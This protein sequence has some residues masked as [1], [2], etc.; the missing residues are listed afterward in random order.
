MLAPRR[1]QAVLEARAST[2]PTPDTEEALHLIHQVQGFPVVTSA[3]TGSDLGDD[4]RHRNVTGAGIH[5]EGHEPGD[6]FREEQFSSSVVFQ[7]AE[8]RLR[9]EAG[10]LPTQ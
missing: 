9:V 1:T 3:R 6:S 10:A 7:E 2:S 5:A 4:P 8:P